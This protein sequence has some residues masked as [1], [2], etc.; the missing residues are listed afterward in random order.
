[1]KYIITNKRFA[2]TF[3]TLTV[4]FCYTFSFSQT[5]PM[6]KM[7]NDTLAVNK[8]KPMEVETEEME[9]PHPFF[10][11]EGLPEEQ[12]G[13]TSIRATALAAT[14]EGNTKGDFAFHI[15]TSLAKNLG[16]HIR[17]DRFL[18]NTHSE[19]MFQFAVIKS[20]DGKS[21]FAPL[22]EFEIP[23][24]KGANRINSL[25][26]FTTKLA[27]PR[28]VINQVIH[29]NP[30]EDMFEG[31][32]GLVYNIVKNIYLVGE[33][34]GDKADG[35]DAMF[36]LVGGIKFRLRDNFLIG[37]G[38]HGPIS[39]NREFSSQYIFQPEYVINTKM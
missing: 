29:Y 38:Y 20:K 12:V 31:S 24:K 23:T 5:E 28:F 17:N 4:L 37:F 8:A 19:I 11:H 16:L 34:M 1:M 25:I 33:V 21:G 26:G 6:Q 15:E 14:D 2:K 7:S 35:E 30:R 27:R 3:L 10:T 32:I 39:K 13:M 9:I 36:S 18:F 22:I